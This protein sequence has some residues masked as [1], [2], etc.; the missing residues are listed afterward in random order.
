M[1]AVT[2][3]QQ[4]PLRQHRHVPATRRRRLVPC[5]LAADDSPFAVGEVLRQ[6]LYEQREHLA[7]I[8]PPVD[9]DPHRIPDTVE[10]VDDAEAFQ[11]DRRIQRIIRPAEDAEVEVGVPV[12]RELDGDALRHVRHPVESFHR[13]HATVGHSRIIIPRDAPGLR[14]LVRRFRNRPAPRFA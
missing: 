2:V 6:G 4:R 8:L 12:E 3:V 11:L 13:A 1:S 10:V 14:R 7:E 5:P 9:L